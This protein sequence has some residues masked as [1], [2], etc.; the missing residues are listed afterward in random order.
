MD[1]VYVARGCGWS[2]Y[3]G[4]G[5]DEVLGVFSTEEKA[6]EKITERICASVYQEFYK[7]EPIYSNPYWHTNWADYEEYLITIHKIDNP[8]VD[9]DIID[10][11]N[12]CS[13][14]Y[15]PDWVKEQQE[16]LGISIF[17]ELE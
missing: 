1:K 10:D 5:W 8:E 12:W 14:T 15:S 4:P 7:G 16:R 11:S 17:R 3:D 13:E 9:P 6:R 2:K